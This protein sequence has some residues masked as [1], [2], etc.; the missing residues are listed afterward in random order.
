MWSRKCVRGPA[1]HRMP[2][3]GFGLGMER[4]V[5][6]ADEQQR[7]L[8][9]KLTIEKGGHY[10]V[11]LLRFGE[12]VEGT[13]TT[14]VTC[15]VPFGAITTEGVGEGPEF[16]SALA[17]ATE[18]MWQRITPRKRYWLTPIIL[19]GLVRG[20]DYFKKRSRTKPE[21]QHQPRMDTKEEVDI[22]RLHRLRRC[23]FKV[24]TPPGRSRRLRT[25]CSV[26]RPIVRSSRKPKSA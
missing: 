2:G 15:T 17:R 9:I 10:L 22:R 26:F 18:P 14:L 21:R 1:I 23:R 12:M 25:S 20:R 13:G 7:D 8:F 19:H 24:R 16:A 4:A 11:C 6:G 3:T 5:K